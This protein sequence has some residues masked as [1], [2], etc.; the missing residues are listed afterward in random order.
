MNYLHKTRPACG[1]K[2]WRGHY[3]VECG[4]NLPTGWDRV[5][6][7]PKLGVDTSPRPHAHRCAWRHI[8]LYNYN[9]LSKLLF[10]EFKVLEEWG[11]RYK[12][13]KN[14]LGTLLIYLYRDTSFS[15]FS[16]RGTYQKVFLSLSSIRLTLL[17]QTRINLYL[18]FSYSRVELDIFSSW[19]VYL[20]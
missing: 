17:H 14:S 5:K 18:I 3:V 19:K 1:F 20:I 6:V 9:K 10:Q 11:L 16:L 15:S 8:S 13:W 4:H 2:T 7:A 12:R